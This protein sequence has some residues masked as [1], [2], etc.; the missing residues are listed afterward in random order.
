MSISL[1][2][3]DPI[4]KVEIL[5][6]LWSASR[7]THTLRVELRTHPMGWEL[8]GLVDAEMHRSAVAKTEDA[9]FETSNRWKAEAIEK[10]W[11]TVP[12]RG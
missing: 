9:V 1:R 4:R 11:M 10:G 12:E 3:Y 6:D 8:R 2:Q 7:K 5:G